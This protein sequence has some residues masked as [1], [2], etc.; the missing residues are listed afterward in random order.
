M[1]FV[2]RQLT[3]NVGLNLLRDILNML[4]IELERQNMETIEFYT[5]ALELDKENAVEYYLGRAELYFEN[6]EYLKALADFEKAIE[7]GEESIK[8]DECY[9]TCLDYKNADALIS[10]LTDSLESE[11]SVEAYTQRA[12]LYEL[13]QEYDKAFADI[14]SAIALEPTN[15]ELY[16][17]RAELCKEI[18]K[19]DYSKA[20]ENSPN[21]CEYYHD[22]AEFY[23]KNG[24]YEKAEQDYNKAIEV[25]KNSEYSYSARAGFYQNIECLEEAIKDYNKA[26]ELC[27]EYENAIETLE[28][29]Y[30]GKAGYLHDRA[31]CYQQLEQF[32][33]A[34]EDYNKTIEIIENS[35]IPEEYKDAEIQH[36]KSHIAEF[37]N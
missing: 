27:P 33:K 1:K 4:K 20:I 16:T 22:R 3:K 12:Y 13:K 15:S 37:Q 5:N 17:C 9:L 10:E 29:L 21:E 30:I 2:F 31:E 23:T 24:E 35:D 25:D 19:Y 14:S 8:D 18:E 32:E 11:K 34:L 36:I 26:L 7:L 28:D 6:Y